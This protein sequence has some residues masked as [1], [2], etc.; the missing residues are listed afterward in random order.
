[1]KDLLAPLLTPAAIA[2]AL[3]AMN[4]LAFAAFGIDKWKAQTGRWRTSESTLLHLA[5]LGG[6]PGAYLGRKLFRHKTRKQP[7]VRHLHTIA[8]LQVLGIVC[9]NGWDLAQQFGK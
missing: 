3:A 1:M 2:M 7:F 5:F 9:W 8:F 6:T 4:V